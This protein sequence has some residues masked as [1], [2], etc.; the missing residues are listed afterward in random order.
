MLR[1]TFDTLVA[2]CADGTALINAAWREGC[3]VV[4]MSIGQA[5]VEFPSLRPRDEPVVGPSGPKTALALSIDLCRVRNDGSSELSTAASY[6]PPVLT[7]N[8]EAIHLL[9][10]LPR[11]PPEGLATR[12]GDAGSGARV[13]D[14]APTQ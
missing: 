11:N 3:D 13:G 1:V 14:S 7:A 2:E 5:A 6:N 12:Q 9:S 10:H 4:L 8:P